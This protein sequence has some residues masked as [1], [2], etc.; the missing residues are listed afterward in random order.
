M[1]VITETFQ[2]SL[3]GPMVEIHMLFEMVQEQLKNF[4][5]LPLET[6]YYFV[7]CAQDQGTL[8]FSRIPQC[9]TFP[10]YH[11]DPTLWTQILK[12]LRTPVT[13]S[14]PLHS[15][16]PFYPLAPLRGREEREGDH[17]AATNAKLSSPNPHYLSFLPLTRTEKG[18]WN[19]T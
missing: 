9:S 7:I 14:A 13:T 2:T 19:P 10:F 8:V 1:E 15:T 5:M 3:K 18:K 12:A 6:R 11:Q 16:N 4:R 17:D